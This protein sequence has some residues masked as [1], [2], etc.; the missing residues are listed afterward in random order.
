MKDLSPETVLNPVLGWWG[1]NFN[2]FQSPGGRSLIMAMI[3]G[4]EGCLV[5]NSSGS[6]FESENS[7]WFIENQGGSKISV[8]GVQLIE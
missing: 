1:Q 5:V 7:R 3:M 4:W 6:W 2:S 8:Q